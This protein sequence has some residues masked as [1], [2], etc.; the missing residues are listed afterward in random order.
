[1]FI[2]KNPIINNEYSIIVFLILLFPY[3][4][5]VDFDNYPN[6]AW[7]GLFALVIISFIIENIIIKISNKRYEELK[8]DIKKDV[9]KEVLEELKNKKN[10]V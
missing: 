5:V 1:M 6:L 10:K 2:K 3:L 7:I 8:K 9:I 4:Y